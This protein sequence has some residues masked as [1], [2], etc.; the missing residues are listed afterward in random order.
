MKYDVE[1]DLGDM[2]YI[3]SFI[4]ID[5][6]IQKLIGVIH[7]QHGDL[8]SLLLFLEKE[9]SRLTTEVFLTDTW[10]ETKKMDIFLLH[11]NGKVI[12]HI[13]DCHILC[14]DTV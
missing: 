4:N 6:G 14:C 5:S 3:P 11:E 2:I 7:R 12:S 1:M 10:K 8:I 13:E 9:E